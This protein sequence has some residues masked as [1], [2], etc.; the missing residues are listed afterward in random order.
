M[1]K[2]L[3]VA[4]ALLLT[5]PAQAAAPACDRA[6]LQGTITQYLDAMLAHDPSTLPLASKVR[7]TEDQQELKLGEGLWKTIDS[8]TAFRQDILD[9]K[10]GVAGVHVK[11][12][13]GGKPVLAAIRIR[14]DGRRIAGVESLLVRSREEGAL[15]NVDNIQKPSPEMNVAPPAGQRNSRAEMEKIALLYPKGLRVGSFVTAGTPFGK[16]AYRFENGMLMAGAQCTFRAGCDDIRGQKIPELARIR[17][18]VAAVD[19]EQ[20]IVWLRM[21]FGKSPVRE[22]GEL[23]MFEMFKVY[24]GRIQAVEAFMK[25]VPLETPF[26]WKY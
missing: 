17:A 22:V 19:E 11:V 10:H 15:F 4:V 9:V 16:D 20:G 24:D 6:C 26:L 12:I 3:F 5:I 25:V 8:L 2:L 1:N 18:M 21:D 7:F 23:S 14:M 13:E